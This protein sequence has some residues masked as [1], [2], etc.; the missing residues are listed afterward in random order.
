MDNLRQINYEKAKTLIFEQLTRKSRRNEK[1]RILK[2]CRCWIW[3]KKRWGCLQV[4]IRDW[5][6]YLLWFRL[7]FFAFSDIVNI[8]YLIKYRR[9]IASDTV[10]SSLVYL[11]F[12][13]FHNIIQALQNSSLQALQLFVVNFIIKVQFDDRTEKAWIFIKV[14]NWRYSS[15]EDISTILRT[16]LIIYWLDK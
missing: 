5:F 11:S 7:W 1:I 12:E 4:K 14:S 2:N 16:F 9:N 15:E 8:D 10:R 3:H 13:D 6:R